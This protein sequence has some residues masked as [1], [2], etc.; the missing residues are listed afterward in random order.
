MKIEAVTKRPLI[1]RNDSIKL[2]DVQANF[3]D[4]KDDL[5]YSDVDEG[6]VDMKHMK[7]LAK[8]D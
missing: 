4:P 3:F 7:E 1:K 2:A 6:T 8:T 5:G